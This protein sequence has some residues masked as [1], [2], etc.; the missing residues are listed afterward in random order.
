MKCNV[1]FLLAGLNLA[2]LA[3]SAAF[4]ADWELNDATTGTTPTSAADSSGHGHTLAGPVTGTVLDKGMYWT[5]GQGGGSNGAMHYAGGGHDS[6]DGSGYL[7]TDTTVAMG[8]SGRIE[9]NIYW[10]GGE[11]TY[12]YYIYS[13]KYDTTDRHLF[14]V[15]GAGS[16][17]FNDR[18]GGSHSDISTVAGAILA[19]QWTQVSVTWD[20]ATHTANLFINGTLK[21]TNTSFTTYNTDNVDRMA[22]GAYA[23]Q[24]GGAWGSTFNGDIDYVKLYDTIPEPASL[25]LLA[26]GGTLFLR[27]RR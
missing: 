20:G 23:F 25:A 18:Y 5:S 2:S 24:A 15:D 22:V 11:G 26:L 10:L 8:G 19:N 1:L 17:V 9:A 12:S 4:I 16:L 14:Y 13:D 21:A 3:A 7:K 27:R 6:L